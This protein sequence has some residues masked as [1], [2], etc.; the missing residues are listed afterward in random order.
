MGMR[1]LI[2]A[3]AVAHHW[4][5]AASQGDCPA[6]AQQGVDPKYMWRC[7]IGWEESGKPKL[8]EACLGNLAQ[9][10]WWGFEGGDECEE[11]YGG[12]RGPGLWDRFL[13]E[14]ST[15]FAACQRER[16]QRELIRLPPSVGPKQRMELL[17]EVDKGCVSK[18]VCDFQWSHFG[19]CQP[20]YEEHV[21]WKCGDDYGYKELYC[22]QVCPPPPP[23]PSP[24]RDAG[25]LDDD[26]TL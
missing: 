14:A 6:F 19:I 23:P 26:I 1:L 24:S 4:R 21:R 7:A 25:M 22:A 20:F 12:K 18:E 13:R 11:Y 2:A 8:D 9:R 5:P 17:I 10:L 3:L 16:M 15:K